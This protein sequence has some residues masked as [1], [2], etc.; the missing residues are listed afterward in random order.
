MLTVGHDC[1][2]ESRPLGSGFE[3]LTAHYTCSSAVCVILVDVI[4]DRLE[5]RKLLATGAAEDRLL[6]ND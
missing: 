5:D 3:S 4:A 6:P 2:R 1:M